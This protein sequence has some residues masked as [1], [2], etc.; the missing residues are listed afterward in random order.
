MMIGLSGLPN[1]TGV[2]VGGTSVAVGGGSVGFVV[3]DGAVVLVGFAGAC[4]GSSI[5]V[6]VAACWQAD[7]ISASIVNAAIVM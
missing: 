5:A 6:G 7:R 3:G 1:R 2:S 4:V